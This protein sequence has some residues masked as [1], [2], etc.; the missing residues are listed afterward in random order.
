VLAGDLDELISPQNSRMMAKLIPGAKLVVIP[1]CGHRVMWE[2]TD[3]C[4]LLITGFIATAHDERIFAPQLIDRESRVPD[5]LDL[6]N[7]SLELFAKWPLSRQ[8]QGWIR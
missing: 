6:L 8:G 7:S 5:K 3:E 4:V 2:A 1:G